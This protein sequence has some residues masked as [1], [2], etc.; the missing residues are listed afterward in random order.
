MSVKV[1]AD[2]YVEADNDEAVDAI[3]REVVAMNTNWPVV[4]HVKVVEL[5]RE[6]VA[7]P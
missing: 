2:L 4:A 3:L 7:R 5:T 6:K 1:S